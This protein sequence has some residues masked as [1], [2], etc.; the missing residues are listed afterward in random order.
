MP[1]SGATAA[2]FRPSTSRCHNTACHRSGNDANAFAAAPPSNAERAVSSKGTPA[3]YA[4]RSS[5]GVA[6][7]FARI[8]STW[9]RR[10]AVSR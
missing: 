9:A 2:G 7:A 6:R 4:V 5:V 1:S 8:R 3:S 10:T